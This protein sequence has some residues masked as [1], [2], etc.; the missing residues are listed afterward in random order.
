MDMRSLPHVVLARSLLISAGL[1][2]VGCGKSDRE[3]LVERLEPGIATG[4]STDPAERRAVAESL[5]D[6]VLAL[7]ADAAQF[8]SADAD[9]TA[10][11]AQADAARAALIE[12]DCVQMRLEIDVLQRRLQGGGGEQPVDM[13][14]TQTEIEALQNRVAQ[15]CP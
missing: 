13:A 7:Q 10:R 5:A 6:D 3:A 14:G 15:S 9:A 12:A 8:A 1:I 4:H 2:L 11:E